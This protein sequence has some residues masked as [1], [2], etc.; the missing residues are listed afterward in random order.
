MTTKISEEKKEVKTAKYISKYLSLRLIDKASYTKEVAGRIVVVPGNS[1]RF[2]KGVYE[3]T[4][5]NEIKFLDNHPNCG[6]VFIRVKSDDLAKARAKRFKDLETREAELKKGKEEL[7][8]KKKALQEGESLKKGEEQ[9]DYSEMTIEKLKEIAEA[10]E[11]EVGDEDSR[12]D[13][14]GYLEKSDSSKNKDEKPKF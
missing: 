14:I 11:I 1:I 12:E 3:T 7:E 8:R 5:E 13:I 9:A 10:R 2:E 4:D 6:N